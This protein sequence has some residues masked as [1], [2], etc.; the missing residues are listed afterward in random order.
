[1]TLSAKYGASL[2]INKNCFSPTGT[3]TQSVSA[4]T[5]ALRVSSSTSAISPKI[6]PSKRVERSVA[7]ADGHLAG[8][9]HVEFV[10]GV[11]GAE[12]HLARAKDLLSLVAFASKPNRRMAAHYAPRTSDSAA[13]ECH[14][15]IM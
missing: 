9:D 7:Q 4:T 15:L 3:T 2:V 8:F 13:A 14:V 10:A 12:N 6:S 5:V 11:S 1:M